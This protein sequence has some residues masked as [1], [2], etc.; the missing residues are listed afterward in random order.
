[1]TDK[2]ETPKILEEISQAGAKGSG[3]P[4][5]QKNARRRLFVVTLLLVP[6]MTTIP[7]LGFQLRELRKE[8]ADTNAQYDGLRVTVSDQN[9][10][11]QV[12]SSELEQYAGAE[13]A[14]L[15]LVE[16]F[17][18]MDSEIE[19]LRSQGLIQLTEPDSYWNIREAEFLLSLANR[20]LILEKD[21]QQKIHI[22]QS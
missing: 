10:R 16:D 22:L 20:K 6:L 19:E 9:T 12:L 1:M 5:N 17:R 14:D 18:R 3:R 4:R 21:I 15:T 13:L 11:I 7:Y 8:I 2:S